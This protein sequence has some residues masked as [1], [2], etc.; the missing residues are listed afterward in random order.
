MNAHHASDSTFLPH[1]AAGVRSINLLLLFF[2]PRYSVPEELSTGACT[3]L[4]LLL[5]LLIR[6]RYKCIVLRLACLSVCLSALSHISS[7]ALS[8]FTKFSVGYALTAAVARS[9]SDDNATRYV[10]PV[11]WMTSWLSR[12]RTTLGERAFS[13]AGRSAWTQRTAWRPTR[14]GRLSEI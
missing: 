14:R 11:L 3:E 10:L 1:C 8:H 9:F 12:L 2:L 5:L 6:L 13:H 4:L 7:T